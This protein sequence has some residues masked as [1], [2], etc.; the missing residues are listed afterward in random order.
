ME[1]KLSPEYEAAIMAHNAALAEY[2][3]AV[4]AFRA[5]TMDYKTFGKAQDKRKIA[6]N[7]FD[8]AFAK[9]SNA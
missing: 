1:T 6:D 8:I 5:R 7:A 2:E 4:K 3:I 9:E